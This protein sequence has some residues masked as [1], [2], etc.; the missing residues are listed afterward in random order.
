MRLARGRCTRAGMLAPEMAATRKPSPK[1]PSPKAEGRKKSKLVVI[2]EEA[3][4]RALLEALVENDWNL[5]AA[6]RALEVAPTHMHRYLRSL[7]LL[8]VYE[9]AKKKR[10]S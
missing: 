8:D 1:K 2:G 6:S 9:D 5:A 7:G 3:M 4:R 10:G